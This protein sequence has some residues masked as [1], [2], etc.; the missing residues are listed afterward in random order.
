MKNIKLL[1]HI[2][3][4]SF[5]KLLFLTAFFNT[6]NLVAQHSKMAV[7]E[8]VA[9][10]LLQ[11]ELDGLDTIPS[12]LKTVKLNLLDSL[13][14]QCSRNL[15]KYDSSL[16]EKQVKSIFRKIDSTCYAFGMFTCINT[17]RLEGAFTKRD[18]T[19]QTR[20]DFGCYFYKNAIPYR[21]K[22][23]EEL[24]YG[25]TIDCDLMSILYYSIGELNGYPI[26]MVEIPHH[27]F[28]R[29]I[30]KPGKYLNWDT[31]AAMVCDD[32]CYRNIESPTAST[33]FSL[34]DEKR[35]GFLKDMYRNEILGY[36]MP[37]IAVRLKNNNKQSEAES[38]YLKALKQLKP[39]MIGL[40]YLSYMYV[41]STNYDE[42]K[43]ARKALKLSKEAYSNLK[44]Y[45]PISETYDGIITTYACSC[46]ANNDFT[47]AV[48]LLDDTYSFDKV[49][50]EG[51]EAKK[52]CNEIYPNRL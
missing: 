33:R 48:K 22:Y 24:N 18:L 19:D 47:T 39:N 34:E 21:N 1:E 14:L 25:F 26:T 10:F 32:N 2:C 46:A 43:F 31:N 44:F 5:Q 35:I 15:P 37:F 9:H 20:D 50:K 42:P 30:F 4:K 8:T 23:I 45:K 13:L 17:G 41:Y 11:K 28:V 6:I 27:N 29:W 51:F 52:Q 3:M 36:Y 38:I 12:N 40:Y 7:N 49:L 16:N